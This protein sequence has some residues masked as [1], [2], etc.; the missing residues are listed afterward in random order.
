M[1]PGTLALNPSASAGNI[2]GGGTTVTGGT[3]S[4]AA[5]GLGS[6]PVV[7]DPVAG[8]N[9]KATLAWNNNAT[10]LTANGLTLNSGTT[11][12]SLNGNTVVFDNA[13]GGSGALEIGGG[14]LQCGNGDTGGTFTS[15]SGINLHSDGVLAFNQVGAPPVSIPIS[16]QGG[17]LAEATGGTLILTNS[18][19]TYQ[20]GTTVT[21]GATV[22]VGNGTTAG[23]LGSGPVLLGN[24]GWGAALV[25]NQPAL[26]GGRLNTVSN[27]ISDPG[28]GQGTVVQLG[29]GAVALTAANNYTGNT[30]V[31]GGELAAENVA[32]IPSGSL[33]AVGANG[34]VVLGTPGAV[35]PVGSLAGAGPLTGLQPSG[36]GGQVASPALSGGVNPVPEPGT[37]ALLAA[38]AACSLAAAWRRKRRA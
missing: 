25:F 33:L 20:G 9:A 15:L 32:A 27:A 7:V 12:F 17:V 24:N 16:G 21:A 18:N 13:I 1:G 5:G 4:F 26:S 3:L 11:V 35:E 22:Q 8:G 10:D 14:T 28:A 2:Y 38:A 34:S 30:A 37:L 23:S 19:N 31:L 6:G 29:P 36:S